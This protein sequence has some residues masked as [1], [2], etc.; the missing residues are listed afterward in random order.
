MTDAN[1]DELREMLRNLKEA[2]EIYKIVEEI[3]ENFT[4]KTT[5][6]V[7]GIVTAL[8]AKV[9]HSAA[10]DKTAGKALMFEIMIRANGITEALFSDEEEDDDEDEEKPLQ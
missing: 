8:V 10:P 2:T 1:S 4:G 3:T 7:L 9:I 5:P 6:I